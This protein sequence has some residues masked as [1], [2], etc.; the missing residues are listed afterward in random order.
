M[1]QDQDM[2]LPYGARGMDFDNFAWEVRPDGKV[3]FFVK[4]AHGFHWTLHPGLCSGAFDLH[5]TWVSPD[6]TTSHKTLFMVRREDFERLAEEIAPV[7]IPGL[8]QQFRPLS[9]RWVRR[10]KISIVRDPSSTNAELAAVTYKKHMRLQFDL[11]KIEDGLHQASS[12]DEILAMPDGW[13]RLMTFRRSETRWFGVG[14]KVTDQTGGLH[15]LWVR[16]GDLLAWGEQMQKLF[17]DAAE[18]Y[19]I[20]PE[21]YPKYFGV[22]YCPRARSE[23]RDALMNALEEKTQYHPLVP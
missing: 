21:D 15:V 18:K 11:Q 7:L 23:S 17:K 4:N 13:F 6:G 14:F 9:L 22:Q 19:L 16:L 10:R 20:P 12:P 5:E 3:H 2:V 8:L 1:N